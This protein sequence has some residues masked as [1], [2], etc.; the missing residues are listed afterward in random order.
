MSRQLDKTEL[1]RLSRPFSAARNAKRQRQVRHLHACGVRP[2]LECL[3]DVA[4]GRDLDEALTDF[5][6]LPVATYHAVGGD[7]FPPLLAVI[8]GGRDD[9]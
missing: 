5:A 7:E 8:E 9:E 1:L 2:V 6:R 4:A 3:I